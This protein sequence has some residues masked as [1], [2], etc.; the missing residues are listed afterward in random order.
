MSSVH[1][2]P[3]YQ[4]VSD[5]HDLSPEEGERYSEL[6]RKLDVDGD[7]RIDVDDLQVGL[8]RL[9]VHTVPGH[10]QKF[11]SKSDQ[12]K[13]GHVDFGEFVKYAIE[14]E[15]QLKLV[16]THIDKNE[17]GLLDVQEILVSLQKLG[18]NVSREDADKLLKSMDKDGTLKVDWN[19]WRNY[20]ILHPSADLRDIYSYWR[21]ASFLDIGEDVMVPDEF[22]EEEKQTGMWWRILA[23]GGA[24]GAVSRTVTAPLDR[25]KVIF[26][27]IGSKKQNLGVVSGFQHMYREGG[28]KSFWR[29]NGINVLKIAPE[30]AI[31]FFAYER[32][33]KLLHT[34][35]CEVRAYERFMAG[36]AA[37]VISQSTIY[38]MEVLKT[39]LAIRKTGQYKG[40]VDCAVQIFK[41]E[42]IL[43]FYKGYI[44]N[45]IGVLPYAGIDLMVYETV[46]NY[47]IKR[48]QGELMPPTLVLLGCGTVSSTCGQLASYPLALVRTRLQA[49]TTKKD[50]MVT[51]FRAIY[52]NEGIRGLYRGITPNFMKVIPAVS[53]GY[54]VY[55]NVK[56][57][58]GAS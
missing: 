48:H 41:N 26:Q 2:I 27:V 56:R 23:S 19:E 44:P 45:C 30:T 28:L 54:V 34:E 39:R 16:F 11:L 53:I 32:I 22:T 6:F 31:K 33:K 20:L 18:V 17:D 21:H 40:I 57:T 43:C 47:W 51:L 9:G 37:G 13:D 10:A 29:G 50:S 15:K 5:K 46:K 3:D 35:G 12:N 4:S 7:G 25:L 1:K 52:K 49:Q 8:H 24:A 14:H 38:P 58:L 36:A 42:G 55:E